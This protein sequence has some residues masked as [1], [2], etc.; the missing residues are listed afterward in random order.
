MIFKIII[1]AQQQNFCTAAVC[2]AKNGT[3]FTYFN[4]TKNGIYRDD[5]VGEPRYLTLEKKDGKNF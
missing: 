5:C 3:F 2:L 1:I 4:S